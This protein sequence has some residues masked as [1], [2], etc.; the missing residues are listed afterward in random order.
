MQESHHL[1]DRSGQ[2]DEHVHVDSE[3]PGALHRHTV[4]RVDSDDDQLRP[5]S[6][7]IPVVLRTV[8]Q[9]D[10]NFERNLPNRSMLWIENDFI[11][12]IPFISEEGNTH[13]ILQRIDQVAPAENFRQIHHDIS[14]Q[15]D[16]PECRSNAERHEQ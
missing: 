1:V 2:L 12:P 15:T 9:H 10:T 14:V 5:D 16:E 4:V 3:Y 11:T 8:R 13:D 7:K 6:S